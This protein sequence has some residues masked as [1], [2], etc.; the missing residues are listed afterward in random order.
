M[1]LTM[2]NHR[3]FF[4]LILFPLFC[5]FS[6]TVA[7]NDQQ[8]VDNIIALEKAPVGVL[9]ELIGRENGKYLPE[10]LKKVEAYKAQLEK[11]FPDIKVAVVTHGSEQFELTKDNAIEQSKTHNIVKRITAENVPVHVCANHASWRGKTEIDF[12]DYVLASSGAG[13]QMKEYQDKG[14]IRILI[15]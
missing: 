2:K 6:F 14:Y 10:G 4:K 13:S 12:P 3:K 7:A 11:K 1:N 9:F 5:F 15:Y 8:K